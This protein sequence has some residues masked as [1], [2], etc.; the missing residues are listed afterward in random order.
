V[1][2][3]L[4]I[5]LPDDIRRGIVDMLAPARAAAPVVS[6][7]REPLLHVTIR[8][9]GERAPGDVEPLAQAVRRAARERAPFRVTVSGGGAFP[10]FRRPRVVWLAMTPADRLTTL[11]ADTNRALEAMGVP[12]EARPFQPHL[13][14]G[15]VRRELSPVEG[16]GLARAMAEL[17]DDLAF[18]VDALTLMQSQLSGAAPV[19]RAVAALPLEGC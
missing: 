10:N 9:L 18:P 3:F 7:T 17:H 19:Y 6:W 14:V 2:L 5:N 11:A 16:A 8:F 13:T 4:A 1:R 12:R 15:R